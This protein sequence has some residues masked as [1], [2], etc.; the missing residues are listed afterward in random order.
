MLYVAELFGGPFDGSRLPLES[1]VAELRIP[2]IEPSDAAVAF[3]M[4][5]FTP[6][7]FRYD[8]YQ[9]DG[10]WN[11]C[12]GHAEEVGPH[13]FARFVIVAHGINVTEETNRFG[14]W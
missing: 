3:Q 14:T 9:L 11:S 5:V 1:P 2:Q 4:A 6:D 8:F 7:L 10:E 13:M 12:E